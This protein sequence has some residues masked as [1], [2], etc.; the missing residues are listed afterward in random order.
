MYDNESIKTESKIWA[1]DKFEPQHNH[2]PQHPLILYEQAT[3]IM[4]YLV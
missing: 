2:L 4:D 1:K 3:P